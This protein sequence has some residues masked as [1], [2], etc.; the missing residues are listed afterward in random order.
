MRY[1]LSVLATLLLID[2]SHSPASA[3]G[4]RGGNA[5]ICDSRFRE[6]MS[7]GTWVSFNRYRGSQITSN[8]C[9]R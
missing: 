8:L 5:N 7:T 4:C 9:K 3:Q 6:C 2:V 1:L